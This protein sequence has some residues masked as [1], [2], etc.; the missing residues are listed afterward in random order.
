MVSLRGLNLNI[1]ACVLEE[2]KL[3]QKT[4]ELFSEGDG[5][6]FSKG[7][8]FLAAGVLHCFARSK[9]LVSFASE[10]QAWRFSRCPSC[11]RTD[12]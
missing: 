11:L 4:L 12:R 3:G 7:Y 1:D 9:Y 5:E 2:A 10:C 6:Y 8:F